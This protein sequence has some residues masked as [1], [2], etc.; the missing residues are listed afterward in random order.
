MEHVAS[1]TDQERAMI[2]AAVTS[3]NA[4]MT[5]YLLST[6]T[7]DITQDTSFQKQLA[8][9]AVQSKSIE[10]LKTVL[11]IFPSMVHARYSV[12]FTDGKEDQAS[13]LFHAARIGS[14]VLV[15]FLF[16]SGLDMKDGT[17]IEELTVLG[18]AARN[19]HLHVVDYL[20]SIS[21]AADIV[22][23]GADPI[24]EAGGGG[25][26]EIFNR[27][28]NIGFNPMQRNKRG[29]T[30]LH[31]ALLCGK[32]ELAFYIMEHYPML[33]NINGRYD[34]SVL[35]YAAEGGSVTLLQHLIEIGKDALYV[36][37]NGL[38][39]LHV[40]CLDRK[41]GTAMYLIQHHQYLLHMKKHTNQTALHL[42]CEGGN[43]DIF[44]IL[45]NAGLSVDD[46]DVNMNN[47][48]HRACI[49]R[50]HEMIEYL[51]HHYSN[52][53][54]QK[55]KYGLYPFHVAARH[56][57]EAILRLFMQHNVDIC[58][59]TSDDQS[60]LHISSRNA[61]I[62]TAQFILSQFPQLIP[63]KDNGGKTAVERAV[64]AGAVD[65]VKLFRKK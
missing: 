1:D 3:G 63:L 13:L 50:N 38:T 47:M 41:K 43:V 15:E 59:L 8:Q 64:E 32:E 24:V 27:L 45:V 22:S 52:G 7:I 40:A 58:K 61:N 6:I 60:I 16:R 20:L 2:R 48:L 11:D 19:G 29:Q 34:R 57:D 53:M 51:L 62:D 28:V 25:S 39:I 5:R 30:A 18:T 37:K 49:R 26:V 42:A 65:I 4:E 46:R 44:N 10:V 9:I 17:S 12:K 55:N 33:I 35:H 54:I 56:G 31:M 23:L 36:D 14:K 21:T